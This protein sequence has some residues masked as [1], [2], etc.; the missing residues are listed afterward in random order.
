MTYLP[1]NR[2][3]AILIA[4]TR[5]MLKV[6]RLV[7]DKK[8]VGLLLTDIV[9]MNRQMLTLLHKKKISWDFIRTILPVS[10]EIGRTII[11]QWL[12]RYKL[13]R[14]RHFI[15]NRKTHEINGTI[16]QACPC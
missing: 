15:L 7:K 4:Q 1:K 9:R 10:I 3:I 5:L 12:N 11:G 2:V 13:R 6:Q 8:V 16:Y 14:N